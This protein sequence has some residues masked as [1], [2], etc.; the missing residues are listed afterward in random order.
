M[1]NRTKQR[2][3]VMA[4]LDDGPATSAEIAAQTGM[5]MRHCSAVLNR[6]WCEG[7][8][9]RTPERMRRDGLPGAF[10]YML[11]VCRPWTTAEVRLLREM[12]DKPRHR[13]ARELGRSQRAIVE[14]AIRSGVKLSGRQRNQWDAAV[15]RR[16]MALR[17]EGFSIR[18]AAVAAGVPLGTLRHWIYDRPGRG[19]VS[20][21]LVGARIAA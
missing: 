20:H 10:G 7:R 4:A 21:G 13:I 19:P 17:R 1:D 15:I 18:S 11:K 3:V 14:Y 12:A 5:P 8:I 6:M 2:D 16:A 9:N